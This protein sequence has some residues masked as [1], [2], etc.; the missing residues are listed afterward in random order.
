MEADL[1]E[2][3]V[4]VGD[5]KPT[6]D[7]FDV[8]DLVRGYWLLLERGTPGEVYNLCSGLAWSI[9]RLLNYLIDKSTLTQIENHRI[10]TSSVQRLRAPP[11]AAIPTQHVIRVL[12]LAAIRL[13]G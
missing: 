7:F 8:R 3:V 6:R 11:H 10:V 1:R 13:H 12:V 5:L 4:Y 2:P 9:E